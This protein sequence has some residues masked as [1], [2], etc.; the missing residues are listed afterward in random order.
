[1]TTTGIDLYSPSSLSPAQIKGAGHS[2]VMY[3]IVGGDSGKW[4]DA[5]H[6]HAALAGGLAVAFNFESTANRALDGAAAGNYD[7]LGC[8]DL[9]RRWMAPAGVAVYFAIDFDLAPSGATEVEAYARAFAAAMEPYR[10][11]CYG[12]IYAASMLLDRNAVDLAFQ[13]VSW[14]GGRWDPR[15][16][17]RQTQVNTIL[18]GVGIDL[19][20]AMRADFGQWSVG[21][22]AIDPTVTLKADVHELA[23]VAA[24]AKTSTPAQDKARL[25]SIEGGIEMALAGAG[26]GVAPATHTL[27]TQDAT[28]LAAVGAAATPTNTIATERRIDSVAATLAA[29]AA[30][31]P[32]PGHPVPEALEDFFMAVTSD[33]Q[34][35]VRWMYRMVL[36]DD[37][38]DDPTYH[39]VMDA[40]AKGQSLGSIFQ[41]IQSSDEGKR[42]LA[43]ERKLLGI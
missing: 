10:T 20:E 13:T 43:A 35:A 33:P 25:D 38:G 4:A 41:A 5:S 21:P 19:D 37:L 17:I 39:H 2:F 23:A 12:G 36:H 40:I 16:A 22:P 42:A 14:S 28:E 24:A 7:G 32:A 15:A 8:H 34:L 29:D 1:M 26:T 9:L 11:G 30:P 18:D 27:I 31:I 6:V 3:Y